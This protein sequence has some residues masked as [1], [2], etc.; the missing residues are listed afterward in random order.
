MGKDPDV[1]VDSEPAFQFDTEPA[2]EPEELDLLPPDEAPSKDSHEP[3]ARLDNAG[4]EV[5][6]MTTDTDD[7]P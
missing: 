4:N 7:L 5:P 6:D 1:D 3:A 2:V